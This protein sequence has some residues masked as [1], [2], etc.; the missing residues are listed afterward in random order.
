[1]DDATLA[2]VLAGIESDNNDGNSATAAWAEIL[3]ATRHDARE[4][5]GA[6]EREY[7]ALHEHGPDAS[8]RQAAR[9]ERLLTQ[10][11]PSTV[12]NAAQW[13][14]G[15]N[16]LDDGLVDDDLADEWT[17]PDAIQYSTSGDD[18]SKTG[19][20]TIGGVRGADGKK[21]GGV[22]VKI[23]GG[24]I[25]SGPARLRGKKLSSFGKDKPP[26]SRL[27]AA[28]RSAAKEHRLPRGELRDAVH[29]VHSEKLRAHQE[30]ESAKAAARRKTGLTAGDISRL[31]N[32][33]HDYASAHKAGGATGAKFSHFDEVAQEVAREH[34]HLGLGDPNE[35][36]A[37]FASRLWN[38]LAEG[39]R[40]AP[41]KHHAEVIDEAVSLLKSARPSKA[42][43][44]RYEEMNAI[45]F[46]T[47]GGS[48]RTRGRLDA[49]YRRLTKLL[50]R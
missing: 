38:V 27:D 36:S 45:P 6:F 37:D 48:R 5:Q 40:D 17:E 23:S 18:G 13:I 34:P 10:L 32:A 9:I 11:P 7:N 1:M 21:H 14:T 30:R 12:R 28:V 29:F 50:R 8:G 25:V 35:K 2:R 26:D 31:A 19:W 33:G 43:R 44:Q 42:D 3:S 39:K 41:A 4:L 22:P 20:V 24:K 47:A 49:P 46:S 15:D 16:N